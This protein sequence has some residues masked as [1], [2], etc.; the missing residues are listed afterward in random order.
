MKFKNIITFTLA[1][2]FVSSAAFAIAPPANADC[3]YNG[4]VNSNGKCA[5][6]YDDDRYDDYYEDD[7]DDDRYEDDDDDRYYNYKFE[8][9]NR[10]VNF[11]FN[12]QAIFALI[13]RL[14]EMIRLLER[15]LDTTSSNSSDTTAQVQTRSA[16]DIDDDRATLRGRIDL[17]R[18]DE[19]EVYF[20]YG[21]SL[22]NLDDESDRQ[23]IDKD[24][25]NLTFEKDIKNLDDNTVYYF[26][27]VSEDDDGDEDYGV[28][29]SFR[30]DDRSSSGDDEPDLETQ[31]AENISEN[32]AELSG[33][34]DMNDFE[35]GKVFFVYGENE[36][37]VNDVEDDYD[38]YADIDEQGDDLQKVVADNDL[39]SS[40]GYQ[41]NVAGLD[42][43][44]RIYYS[45]C[46]EFEDG[47]DEMIM[48][49]DTDSFRTDDT[50]TSNLDLPDLETRAEDNVTEDE[51][52]LN[53]FVDMNDFNNGRVFFVYGEDE[54][55]VEDVEDDYDTYAEIDEQGDDLQKVSVDSDLDSSSSYQET[56][57]NL[58]PDTQIYYSIC[59]GFDD[60]DDDPV[61]MCDSSESFVTDN[62]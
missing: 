50:G 40:S 17:N 45:I 26:R 54:S 13:A 21:T 52:E 4:Y 8:N 28:I 34:V 5:K 14:Q 57:T 43:N 2:A 60:E 56:V 32:E 38:T 33:F 44:T 10:N 3:S 19:A 55:I 7:D 47:N 42:P 29:L 48:C 1:L 37:L 11:G 49:G 61:I 12:D 30:T 51:A 24:D 25:I 31:D 59:V 35:N 41:E 36:L 15:R 39:N 20:E 46:V 22:R 16:V 6:S 53:G 23:T 9:R 18:E 27:A 58:D 62:N